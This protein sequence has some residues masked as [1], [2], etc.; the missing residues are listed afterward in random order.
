MFDKLRKS[1]TIAVQP[2]TLLVEASPLPKSCGRL[3]RKTPT[4]L[5]EL[6]QTLMHDFDPL[7]MVVVP[8]EQAFGN[9]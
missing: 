1:S 8:L 4:F 3:S 2:P 5:V 9:Q 7:Q 6:A